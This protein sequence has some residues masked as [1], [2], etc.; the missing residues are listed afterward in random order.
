MDQTKPTTATRHGWT[1]SACGPQ[2]TTIT[3]HGLWRSPN[4]FKKRQTSY[5]PFPESHLWAKSFST[6]CTLLARNSSPRF[7]D[8]QKLTYVKNL[9]KTSRLT[10]WPLATRWRTRR[11]PTGTLP[12][13]TSLTKTSTLCYVEIGKNKVDLLASMH[14]LK[15]QR[16]TAKLGKTAWNRVLQLC[17]INRPHF[18]RCWR[19]RLNRRFL[20]V[21]ID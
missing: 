15:L 21:K 20:E 1:K 8:P 19:S 10:T 11:N 2:P 12:P 5:V 17:W 18:W 7:S 6:K 16:R 4:V 3:W 13:T 14:M 9:P